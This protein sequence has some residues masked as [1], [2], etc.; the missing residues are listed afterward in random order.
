MK[1]TFYIYESNILYM[2]VTF[3]YMKVTFLYI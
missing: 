3:L 1:V 2:K